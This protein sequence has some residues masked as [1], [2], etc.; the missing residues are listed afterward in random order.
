MDTQFLIK[1]PLSEFF[2]FSSKVDPFLMEPSKGF[3]EQG[4][5][6]IVLFISKRLIAR[7]KSSEGVLQEEHQKQQYALMQNSAK[8]KGK[9]FFERQGSR[10]KGRLPP[11]IRK[12]GGKGGSSGAKN[13]IPKPRKK[14]RR[15]KY[16]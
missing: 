4:S 9:K 5:S 12:K 10:Q 11:K 16:Y 15:D 7:V 1:S 13:M 14:G 8:E 6:K 3:N 2:N